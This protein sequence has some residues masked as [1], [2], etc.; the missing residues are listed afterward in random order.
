VTNNLLPQS[1]SHV[2]ATVIIVNYNGGEY[3][4][5]CLV[6]LQHQTRSPSRI[7]V[8]DNASTDRSFIDARQRFPDCSFLPQSRN[9]GFAAGNNLAVKAADTKY[10]VLLNPDAFPEPSWLERL[11]DAAERYPE[12]ASLG[13]RQMM[14][15]SE[16]LL[17][18]ISDDYHFSGLAW[19]R[20]YGKP[21]TPAYH[22]DQKIFSPCAAAAL[23]RRD[24]FLEVGGF[25]EDYFCYFEDVDL[26]FRLRLAG[27]ESYYIYDAVVHHVGSGT[28]GGRYS[29]FSL[30]HGHRNLVWTYIKNLPLSLLIL[31]LPA[32]FVMTTLVLLKF[33]MVG[34]CQA[35]MRSKIDA[36]KGLQVAIL[37]RKQIQSTRRITAWQLLQYIN[38]KVW[39]S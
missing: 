38:F 7:I 26:G 5:K 28:T 24:N 35:I 4:E 31:F 11:V 17:D 9:L 16:G 29:D 6:A 20:A 3:L 18:G 1:T 30:Y 27:Y 13:S 32:H 21:M 12:A 36:I 34:K 14:D 19:R 8:I 33:C 22:C 23:Y 37:K 15:N 25:D 10:V 2:D 39:K